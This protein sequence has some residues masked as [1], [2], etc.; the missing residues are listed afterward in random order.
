MATTLNPARPFPGAGKYP[1]DA[2]HFDEAFAPTGTPRPPYVDAARRARAAGPGGAARA[3]PVQRRRARAHLRAGAADRRRPGAAADRRAPSGSRSKPGLLQRARALNAFLAD[4]YGGQRIFDAGVVPRRLLETSSGYEPRMRGLLDPGRAAGD[5]RRTRPDPRRGRRAAGP[6]GQPADALRRDL[7][8]GGARSGRAGA[9]RRRPA[10]AARTATSRAL[11][12]AIRAAAPRPARRAA[13]RRSSPTAPRAAPGTSTAGS[14]ANSAIPVVD[15]APARSRRAAASTRASRPRARS[16][17]TSSTAA[18]TRTASAPPTASLRALGE[19]LLPALESG[20]LRCVNAFGTGVADDKLAHAYVEE[21]IRF[22]LGEEPLLRSVPSFD[23]SD[24]RRRKRGDGPPRRAGDQAARR[25]RRPRGDDHA[26]GDRGRSGGGRSGWCGG[27]P[28]RFVAQETVRSPPTRPSAAAA[29]GRAGSTCGP[30][31]S[32]A[33]GGGRRRCRAASPATPAAPARWSSTAPAAAAAR[34][35][36]CS[37]AGATA[38]DEAALPRIP[39]NE[40]PLIGV[41][42]S[43]VRPAERVDPLPEGEPR[44]HEMALGLPYLQRD[45]GGRRAAGGDAAARRGG[46][47]AAARP[48]RRDLP[49]RRPRPRP[50]RPTAP[51]RTPSWARPSPT[52]TA[53]SS[54]SRAAPTPARCR[55]WRS[56][57]APR[58]ST[59]SAAGPSTSTCPTSPTEIPHRQTDRRR[60]D[61]PPGRG[62]ARTAAWPRPS[63]A[64]VEIDVN[65]FHHQAIDRLGEGLVVS[66]RAPDGTIEAIE[67]PS[68][69]FL[70]GVQWHAET[71]VHRPYEAALF[72][73]LRRGLPRR[74]RRVRARR[75]GREVA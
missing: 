55:S 59:S 2:G 45:R 32:A 22:Y 67:D 36:G 74:R 28:E 37:R 25:L 61:Q 72:R 65:S 71:L 7:R 12:E 64:R 46:D 44:G 8:D 51:S 38:S 70:I 58:R 24:E 57:A 53:S 60:P 75:G 42:T 43:E 15:P 6:R 63:A 30:S 47:R 23:L 1:L 50:G 16:S 26:A 54:P 62:R 3:R 33:P 41:T 10:A 56:A 40:R 14:A 27:G 31:S 39:R 20:R 29:C 18:S 66:A 68:R 11:G 21:M 69:R 73:A 9:R 4:A 17:S 5:R 49:L 48:A 13:A 52:S 19:L 34:T 35:P